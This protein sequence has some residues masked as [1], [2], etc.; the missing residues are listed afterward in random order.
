MGPYSVARHAGEPW[1]VTG[2]RVRRLRCNAWGGVRGGIVHGAHMAA[3]TACCLGHHGWFGA[4][5]RLGAVVAVTLFMRQPE[6]T[7]H[8]AP[9][10]SSPTTL[11]THEHTHSWTC[12][13]TS[14]PAPVAA[15][16]AAA[17]RVVN[18]LEADS[19]TAWARQLRARPPLHKL[20]EHMLQV[21]VWGEGWIEGVDGWCF[22]EGRGG[23]EAHM[24]RSVRGSG[25]ANGS[26]A[27]TVSFRRS[28]AGRQHGGEHTQT[29]L[30]LQGHV[31]VWP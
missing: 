14:P 19:A 30:C 16:A 15:A 26:A 22:L 6:A 11:R 28:G 31:A 7:P 4:G 1:A 27:R 24:R 9:P 25:N 29:C 5:P 2:V 17:A 13:C 8:S 20:P 21:A 12:T 18:P 3:A 23:G 10:P